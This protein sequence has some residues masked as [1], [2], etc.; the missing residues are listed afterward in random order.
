M[1]RSF[2]WLA[3]VSV[4]GL[5]TAGCDQQTIAPSSAGSSSSSPTANGSPQ[6]KATATTDVSSDNA[7]P[8]RKSYKPV[9]LTGSGSASSE[10]ADDSGEKFA[11]VRSA[12]KPLQILIGSWNGTSRNAALD[13]PGWAWD[14]KTDPKQPALKI[15]SEKGKYIREGRLTFHPSTQEFEFTATDGD[16]KQ[17]NFRGTFSE[18]V[19]DVP[20]DD[21]KLQRTYKLQL[22]EQVAD[23]AGEQW[24]LVIN[25]Q[26][27]NRYILEVDRKRGTGAFNRVD[28]IN[29]QREG[30]SFALSDTDYGDKTCIISQGLGTIS[31][32]YKGKSYW[33]CCSGC[34][35]AF[36]DEPDKWIAKFEALQKKK[37]M[38]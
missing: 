16:G 24:R 13:Q 3:L 8:K 1:V 34:K 5:A 26:E 35:A 14:L 2:S 28:T 38:K 37:E 19:Q 10:S 36:E 32:S 30:T 23:A 22:T 12:L 9:E 17:H 11:S 21:K 29:T 27:N 15:K 6:A 33:V 25:Q 7:K 31:V 4:M 18:P 20:G